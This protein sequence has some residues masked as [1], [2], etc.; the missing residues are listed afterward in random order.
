[1]LSLQHLC[2]LRLKMYRDLGFTPV[3]EDG[4]YSK[5][6]VRESRSFPGFSEQQGRQPFASS[7][8]FR[9]DYLLTLRPAHSGSANSHDAATV[10][11]DPGN[12]DFYWS[13]YLWKILSRE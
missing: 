13:N 4:I 1:M 11:I 8:T 2:R 6:L 10:R 7:R 5:V 9:N 12:N 3:E